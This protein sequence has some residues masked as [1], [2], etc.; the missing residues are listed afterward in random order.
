MFKYRV[1]TFTIILSMLLF[2]ATPIGSINVK[3]EEVE[4]TQNQL[5]DVG[6][7]FIGE[8]LLEGAI[9]NFDFSNLPTGVTA[10]DFLADLGA[11]VVE[12]NPDPLLDDLGQAADDIWNSI[13][14]ELN[15]WSADDAWNF[16]KD[17][18]YT[19]WYDVP[20]SPS[21]PPLANVFGIAADV[22]EASGVDKLLQFANSE[23]PTP[24]PNYLTYLELING[25]SRNYQYFESDFFWHDYNYNPN[26]L[27]FINFVGNPSD[28]SFVLHNY[29]PQL[30]WF[31]NYD[32]ISNYISFYNNYYK[33]AVLQVCDI[34]DVNIISNNDNYSFLITPS[35]FHNCF[36]YYMDGE[37]N[38]H[39]SGIIEYN[40]GSYNFS[41]DRFSQ[42]N[43]SSFGYTGTLEDCFKMLSMYI[44]NCNIFVDGVLWSSA[45]PPD[46]P[47]ASLD[48][49]YPN[50]EP[51]K[52]TYPDGTSVDWNRL[53]TI[54]YNAVHDGI[55]LDFGDLEDCFVD[56]NGQ[57]AIATLGLVRND[58]DNLVDE[59]FN[60]VP[61][62]RFNNN[63]W[64]TNLAEEMTEP[65]QNGVAIIEN[66]YNI[67]PLPLQ[68]ALL[69]A[70]ALLLF[71]LLI[72]RF[73]E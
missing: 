6:A 27:G 53:Y 8:R 34:L 60:M 70:G 52:Y 48:L 5:Q 23:I 50:Y 71:G 25:K 11:I 3:A 72:R 12:G 2:Y 45:T 18:F 42:P 29:Y 39:Y 35:N 13:E 38:L 65:A 9:E 21:L 61:Y 10:D 26:D 49:T 32:Y 46:N 67:F 7:W 14:L 73:L 43:T 63:L 22:L 24:E 58:Y 17:F 37:Q 40:N 59:Q 36:Y 44:R 55:V 47:I 68:K 30:S 69:F 15:S 66:A 64:L 16:A 57:T 19:L 51:A 28:F 31:N 4:Y 1:L 62:P 20:S 41:V 56:V 54:I 33:T